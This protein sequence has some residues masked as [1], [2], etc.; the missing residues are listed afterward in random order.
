MLDYT[1]VKNEPLKDDWVALASKIDDKVFKDA[2]DYSTSVVIDN[3]DA[4]SEKF[5]SAGGV[6]GVYQPTNN[7]DTFLYSDWT[8]SFWTGMVW[9]TY[10]ATKNEKAKE[11]GLL[12]SK[13]FRERY[14][15][16]DILDHHD[17][18]FLYSLSCVA[19]YKLTNDKF[20]YET[21]LLAAE[22]LTTR[23]IKN[24]GM[25]QQ[26]GSTTDVTDPR[27]GGSI[28][29]GCMNLPLL[30]WA[31]NMTGDK[32]YYDMAYSHICLAAKHMVTDRG[33]IHQNMK[34]NV[35]TGELER[36]YTG[37]GKGGDDACWTRGQGWG[38]YGMMLS[39]LYTGDKDL[40]EFA[41]R[42]TNFFLNRL[43]SDY[44]PNWDFYYTDDKDQR[45]TSAGTIT[46]CGILELAKQ[47]P[48]TDP[49]RAVY[50]AAAKVM[51]ASLTKNYL[52]TREESPNALLKGGVYA[53]G[54]GLCVNEPVIW[55]DYYYMEALMRLTNL[56]HLYW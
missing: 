52:Y 47:L 18:G 16:N 8:S 50:E 31:S 54:K 13:S 24:C 41:K 1:R 51:I 36:V 35:A 34:F 30:Y 42:T 23:Y 15:K 22:K 39:Y 46:A 37:Q 17:I 20:S 9:L 29:D 7:A 10:E 25:L 27:S 3:L 55:G 2:L 43:Q 19:A 53:F 44:T 21:A 49:D 38:I 14:E 5:P 26:G 12:Q 45:D 56:H 4:F 6:D 32:K 48:L 11:V 33:A 40:V 28:I